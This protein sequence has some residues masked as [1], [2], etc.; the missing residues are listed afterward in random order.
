MRRGDLITMAGP[1]DYGKP[2]P[3]VVVQS[4]RLTEADSVIVCPITTFVRG[5]PLFRLAV[6]AT[7]ETGLKRPSQIMIEKINSI[8]R[9]RC[10]A[11]IGR[12]DADTL[13]A[14]DQRLAFV[15]GLADLR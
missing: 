13:S 5:A 15:I 10:G 6:D 14:L 4:D 3:A 2:R 11:V 7:Q 9:H 12:L 1:G 8:R